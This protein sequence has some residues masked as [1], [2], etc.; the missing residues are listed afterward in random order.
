[1]PKFRRKMAFFSRCKMC[2]FLGKMAFF[3]WMTGLCCVWMSARVS[4]FTQFVCM[5]ILCLAVCFFCIFWYF[6]V[7]IVFSPFF[8]LTP[9]A[10]IF[11]FICCLC[12]YLP[13]F[14]NFTPFVHLLYIFLPFIPFRMRCW[15]HS[16]YFFVFV[17][18]VVSYI[19]FV[20]TFY[21]LFIYFV[22]LSFVLFALYCIV[23]SSPF[24]H[25]KSHLSRCEMTNWAYLFTACLVT[26]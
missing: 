17:C 26:F 19:C 7:D 10:C 4:A 8:S 22:C 15:F 12:L 25:A 20:C 5:R 13:L 6:I 14:Y 16:L 24:M 18:F 23:L 21:V 2:R 3:F 1:M 9:F 11:Y